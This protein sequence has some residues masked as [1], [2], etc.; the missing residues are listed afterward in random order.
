MDDTI[1]VSQLT[2]PEEIEVNSDPDDVVIKVAAPRVEVEP[3]PEAVEE[4]AEAAEGEAATAE[5][6][7][8][9]GDENSEES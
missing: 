7:T 9:A 2:V 4:G 3:E 5:G 8:P 1:R 6:E